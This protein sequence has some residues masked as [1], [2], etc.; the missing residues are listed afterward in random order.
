MNADATPGISLRGFRSP[1]EDIS[2]PAGRHDRRSAAVR[3]ALPD[4]QRF[5]RVP[6]SPCRDGPLLGNARRVVLSAPL[7]VLSDEAGAFRLAHVP[8][9]PVTLEVF[10]AESHVG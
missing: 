9:G 6:R 7:V 1:H 3:P 10:F 2:S 8:V 4:R 5:D